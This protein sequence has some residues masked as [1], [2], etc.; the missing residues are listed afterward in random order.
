MWPSSVRSSP[1]NQFSNVSNANWSRAYTATL[2]RRLSG[3]GTA[4]TPSIALSSAFPKTAARSIADMKS[5]T[6]PSTTE[7]NP[8]PRSAH[9][10]LFVVR[11][12]SRTPL[13]V[14]A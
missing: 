5:S 4:I 6:A 7:V 1:V 9:S 13:P 10:A 8:I 14:S 3:S 11:M 2:M 12:T